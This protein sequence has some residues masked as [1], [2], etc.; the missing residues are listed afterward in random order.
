MLSLVQHCLA[1]IVRS[2]DYAKVDAFSVSPASL[3]VPE[4]SF[5][6]IVLNVEGVLVGDA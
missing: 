2:S 3:C 4:V 6:V 5:C 1:V